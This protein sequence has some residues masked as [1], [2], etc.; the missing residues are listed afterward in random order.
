M[1]VN[2]HLSFVSGPFRFVDIYGA[3]KLVAK[4]Q[5]FQGVYGDMFAPCQLLI[6]HAKDPSRRFHTK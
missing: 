5:E 3:D 6:D 2:C 1:L 4:L